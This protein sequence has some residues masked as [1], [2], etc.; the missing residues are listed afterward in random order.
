MKTRK[1]ISPRLPVQV[2]SKLAMWWLPDYRESER[3]GELYLGTYM[4]F[5]T[6]P[7]VLITE[8]D[9]EYINSDGRFGPEGDTDHKLFYLYCEF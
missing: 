3:Y 4:K 6:E 1:F 2:K 5:P 7:N 8:P 9:G